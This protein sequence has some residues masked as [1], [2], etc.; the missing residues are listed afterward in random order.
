MRPARSARAGPR[1]AGRARHKGARRPQPGHQ[2]AERVGDRFGLESRRAERGLFGTP[3]ARQPEAGAGRLQGE[4]ADQR[5]P[6]AVAPDQQRAHASRRREPPQRRF[7]KGV[8]GK[9][10]RLGRAR[11]QRSPSRFMACEIV[12]RDDF[13]PRRRDRHNRRAP[14]AIAS[15][16]A[17]STLT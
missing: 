7:E 9:D 8:I 2:R 11:L 14:D 6:R 15:S 4:G 16:S 3:D 12:R 13:D 17:A 10:V 1:A 5:A